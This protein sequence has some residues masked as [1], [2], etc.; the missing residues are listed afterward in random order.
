MA[1]QRH[2]DEILGITGAMAPI[3][4]L[5][6]H[7]REIMGTERRI[8][9]RG[10]LQELSVGQAI[11]VHEILHEDRIRPEHLVESGTGIVGCYERL[12]EALAKAEE[13]VELEAR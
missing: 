7:G 8:Q 13:G 11:E 1:L 12:E 4:F 2:G 9:D 5:E 6:C 3:V 10:H